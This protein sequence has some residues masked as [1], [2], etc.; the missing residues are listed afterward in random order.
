[1]VVGPEWRRAVEDGGR[2][3]MAEVKG[4]GSGYNCGMVLSVKE[5]CRRALI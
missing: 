1:M 5:S 2:E 3:V 4:L